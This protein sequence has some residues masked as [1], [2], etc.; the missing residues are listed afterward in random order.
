MFPALPAAELA[1]PSLWQQWVYNPLAER[2][3]PAALNKRSTQSTLREILAQNI[4]LARTMRG[5]SQEGLG[6]RSNL[7]RT[8]IG[9]VERGEIN[10]GIDT[11]ERL[12][13]AFGVPAS[14]LVD[15]AIPTEL[16]YSDESKRRS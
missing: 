6:E 10:T 3:K 2:Y 8:Y 1:V 9:A 14:T 16:F 11:L 15:G 5:W 4:R 7:Y 13:A 12:A